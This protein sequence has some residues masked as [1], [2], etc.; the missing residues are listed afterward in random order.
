[1]P[2]DTAETHRQNRRAMQDIIQPA[3]SQPPKRRR[4]RLFTFDLSAGS[5]GRLR[6]AGFWA[7]W[8]GTMITSIIG[9][10]V[11]ALLVGWVVLWFDRPQG[12]SVSLLI[13]GCVAF[14]LVLGLLATLQNRLQAHWRLRQVEAALLS[15]MSHNLRTPIS[16]IRAAAQAIEQPGLDEEQRGKLIDAIVQ[17]TRR[18]SLRV[19]NVLETGRLEVTRRIYDHNL[20]DLTDLV[21]SRT[22]ELRGVVEHRDG[23]LQVLSEEAI[24]VRGDGRG[25]QLMIDNL[26]DNAVSYSEGAPKI[27]VALSRKDDFSLL[28][29]T[30]S[31]MGIDSSGKS[32]PFKR[33]WRGDTGRKGTGLG[34]PLARAIARGH[35]GEVNLHS[36]GAGQGA[37]VEVWL[38]LMEG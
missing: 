9:G 33:Y 1:M 26:L 36:D 17:E 25:L 2:I 30:D 22:D 20:V 27:Q 38:P 18:L 32:Q 19:D 31:G 6:R 21:A 14:G 13:L 7:G 15:G 5:G 10:I 29:I 3:I 12:P 16:G 23:T 37:R 34:L 35:G 11:V 8:R 4:R 28:Q 24:Q